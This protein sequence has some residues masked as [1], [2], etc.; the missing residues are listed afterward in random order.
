MKISHKSPPVKCS[1]IRMEDTVSIKPNPRNPKSHPPGQLR[2]Y[3]KILEHQGW[4]RPLVVSEKS[5]LLVS[6]HGALQVALLAKWP[7]VPVEV[8]H[9]ANEAD[10]LAHML[11][12]NKLAEA[13]QID[14]NLARILEKELS[15]QGMDLELVG[16]D[17][18]NVVE[19]GE[20]KDL[21]VMAAP[22]RV[23]CVFSFATKDLKDYQ[24]LLD[25]LAKRKT[26]YLEITGN[27][28]D[29]KD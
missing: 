23:W 16:L 8:Q 11:A 9:F 18:A 29:K 22:T 19:G 17:L 10:E 1:F 7:K 12:D 15:A 6:G 25:Q 28:I 4:R 3:R 13:G 21:A 5:G 2:L 24:P 26:C 20:L 14:G 27:A